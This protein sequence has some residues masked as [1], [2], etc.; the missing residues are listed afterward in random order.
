MWALTQLDAGTTYVVH[1]YKS[2]HGYLYSTT[3]L[4]P[5]GLAFSD[6][7]GARPGRP[8]GPTNLEIELAEV[9]RRHIEA[10]R[11]E[12][13]ATKASRPVRSRLARLISAS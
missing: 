2:S 3:G 9:E 6:A 4:R 8:Q 1:M 12:R 10:R 11:I 5:F 7:T 13:S